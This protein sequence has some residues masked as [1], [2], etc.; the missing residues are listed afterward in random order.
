MA[1]TPPEKAGGIAS[2]I[3]KHACACVHVLVHIYACMC[4]CVRMI[5]CMH[6]S[7]CRHANVCMHVLARMCKHSCARGWVCECTCMC[8]CVCTRVCVCMDVCMDLCVR[9]C[10]PAHTRIALSLYSSTQTNINE[11]TTAHVNICHTFWMGKSD[12]MPR[13]CRA[14]TVTE[15]SPRFSTCQFNRSGTADT[16][17]KKAF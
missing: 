11:P 5:A 14:V 9:M 10:M 8:A 15:E 6:V 17:R 1:Q 4:T 7:V 2:R 16:V 12:L 13:L 3:K